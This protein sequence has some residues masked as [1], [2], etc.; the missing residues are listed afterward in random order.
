M[1]YPEI[2]GDE[3]VLNLLS[4]KEFYSLKADP[5][6]NFRDPPEAEGD[7]YANKYLKAQ[8]H[9]LF[10]RNF[11][12][13]NTNK[14]RLHAGHGT[15]CHAAGTPILMYDGT[16][17][18]VED[19]DIGEQVMG[20]DCT[21]RNVLDTR[22]GVEKMYKIVPTKGES[23]V[24]NESHILS[25][26]CNDKNR[27]NYN[28][29]IDISIK[30]YITKSGH[31]KHTYKLFRA[32]VDF[33]EIPVEID[34]YIIGFWLGDGTSNNADITTQD[35]RIIQ[36][37]TREVPKFGAYFK[38]KREYTY[39][40][41]TGHRGGKKGSNRLLTTLQNYNLIKNKHIPYAY[42]CTS[43]ENRLKLLAGLIDSDGSYDD[44]GKGYDFI[45][46]NERLADDVV[47][48]CR[49]LGFGAYKNPCIKRC[50]NSPN[51]NHSDTYYRI[52]ISGDVT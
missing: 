8:S 2:D 3:A 33:P 52:F 18:N 20:D 43:R 12:N 10:V 45:Q 40:V 4:R 27:S 28:K 17:R 19:V 21:P 25:L 44:K 5:N 48:L 31:F 26:K 30:D 37:F 22:F 39:S 32:K 49:S 7:Y 50:K 13:P 34:P 42:K 51:P 9:Q 35:A 47:Y 16:I 24:C 14:K 46:K 41:T 1:S 23:F 6:R 15:G 36:Y 29:T 38:H 11:M